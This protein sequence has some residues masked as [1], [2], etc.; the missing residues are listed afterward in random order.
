[1]YKNNI[2]SI[3]YINIFV[4]GAET[5]DKFK[6]IEKLMIKAEKERKAGANMYIY[7]CVCI[8]NMFL[9]LQML[10]MSSYRNKLNI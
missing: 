5:A 8:N 1:M 6:A 2:Y 9:G 4:L 10:M 3:V 7:I